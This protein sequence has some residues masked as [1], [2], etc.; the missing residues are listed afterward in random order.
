MPSYHKDSIIHA[1][2]AEVLGV[3]TELEMADFCLDDF[4]SIL[5]YPLNFEVFLGFS[6]LGHPRPKVIR[7][8]PAVISAE[9]DDLIFEEIALN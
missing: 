8:V 2:S 4:L 6:F 9:A 1:L 7:Q 3:A 5:G